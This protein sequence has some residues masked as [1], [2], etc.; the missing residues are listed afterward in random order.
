MAQQGHVSRFHREDM[1]LH[2]HPPIMRLHR[3]RPANNP[4][5]LQAGVHLHPPLGIP[6]QM[7]TLP[8]GTCWS[9]R[10]FCQ[11]CISLYFVLHTTLGHSLGMMLIRPSL[12]NGRRVSNNNIIN[13]TLSRGMARMVR[14]VHQGHRLHLQMGFRHRRRRL[15][16]DHIPVVRVLVLILG[17][18]RDV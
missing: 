13:T 1:V 7:H 2:P 18:G 4:H 12:K 17:L 16:H 15:L 5:H 10:S 9:A 14:R 11:S 6:L 8:I 3:H